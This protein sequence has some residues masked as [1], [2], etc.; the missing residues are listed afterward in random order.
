MPRPYDVIGILVYGILLLK[1]FLRLN[2]TKLWFYTNN[3]TSVIYYK[4]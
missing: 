2:Y 4:H 1:V 3:D